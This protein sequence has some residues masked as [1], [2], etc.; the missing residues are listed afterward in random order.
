MKRI[1]VLTSGGDAPGMNTAVR[2]V[3]RTAL[4]HGLETYGI[5]EGYAGLLDGRCHELKARDVGDILHRGGTFLQTARCAAMMTDDGPR[6]AAQRI[7]EAE[8][9]GIV[10]IGG[11]GSL[12]GALALQKQGV[13][14]VG[15]PASIDNDIWGTNMSIGVDTALNTIMETVDK[16]RDT[17]SSHQ[18][19]FLIETMGRNCGYLAL[20]AGVVC[21]AEFS[22]I[23]EVDVTLEEIADAVAAAYARGKSHSMILVAE[24]ASLDIRDVAQ[25]L[26]ERKL[27]Y[28]SRITILGH[29]QRGGT[30]TAFDRLLATR[31]GVAAV[32]ALVEGS[33]GVMTA[34]SGREITRVPLEESV[35][36]HRAANLAFHHMTTMLAR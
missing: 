34:L 22:L 23:P 33:S 9:D 5:P 4:A 35:A 29:V 12:A 31:L 21:G 30:P 25:Y 32:D 15:V 24:G 17:A 11:D 16:L 19:A 1:G 6:V 3:V 20:M 26:D 7:A 2:A 8:I 36:R 28:E 13:P 10:V 14:T 27:G 18:R